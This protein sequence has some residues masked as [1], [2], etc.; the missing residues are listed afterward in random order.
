[1]KVVDASFLISAEQIRRWDLL[2][3]LEGD[4][5]TP[6]AIYKEVV[7]RGLQLGHPGAQETKRRLFDRRIVRLRDPEEVP[8]EASP[9]E[10]VLKLA[11]EEEADLYCDDQTLIRRAKRAG[12]TAYRSPDALLILL[13][14]GKLKPGEYRALLLELRA[15]LRIDE[16]TL[17]LYLG[18]GEHL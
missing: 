11:Q 15:R 1:M 4:F 7:E 16:P 13:K 5:L 10:L 12:L 8:A 18:L 14:A 2:A 3:K 6:K 9:D 17:L